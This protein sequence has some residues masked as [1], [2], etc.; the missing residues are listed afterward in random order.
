MANLRGVRESGAVRED[1]LLELTVRENGTVTL[2]CG[3]ATSEARSPWR[4]LGTTEEPPSYR[5]VFSGLVL[6]LVHGALNLAADLAD[7]HASYQGQ[8]QIGLRL[9]GLNGAWAHEYVQHDDIDMIQPYNRDI[10]QRMTAAHTIELA[11]QA[12]AV[13]ERLVAPLLRGLAIDSRYL[14]YATSPATT[15]PT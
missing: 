15:P 11:D 4:E 14:P 12:A 2:L 3:R 10:F 13:T 6:G 1:S 5:V 8:W 9:T 7:R